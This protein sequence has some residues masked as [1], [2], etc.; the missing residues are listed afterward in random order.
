[1][2]MVL[3]GVRCKLRVSELHVRELRGSCAYLCVFFFLVFDFCGS[4]GA[5]ARTES[6]SL[7]GE[8]SVLEDSIFVIFFL[9]TVSECMR[10]LRVLS[11]REYT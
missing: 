6:I 4:E 5:C 10:E 8:R 7:T 11:V 2:Y 3:V 9:L 1:M